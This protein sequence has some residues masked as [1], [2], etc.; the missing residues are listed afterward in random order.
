MAFSV[1]LRRSI[2]T[3]V[4]L[5]ARVVAGQRFCHTAAA[6]SSLIRRRNLSLSPNAWLAPAT[7]FHSRRN[8]SASSD[9][10]LLEVIESEIQ[11]AL[12]SDAQEEVAKFV[13]SVSML[14]FRTK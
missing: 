11:C 1:I 14:Y 2:S 9:K 3:V 6:V 4:P 8:F 5:A 13:L 12:D 10:K 7:G